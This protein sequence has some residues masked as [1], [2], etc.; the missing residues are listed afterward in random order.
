LAAG[1]LL[2]LSPA[3]TSHKMVQDLI[4]ANHYFLH[5]MEKTVKE[6]E[7]IKVLKKKRQKKRKS[8]QKQKQKEQGLGRIN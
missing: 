1:I 2:H 5:L 7:M 6:G 3:G 4:L 8:A